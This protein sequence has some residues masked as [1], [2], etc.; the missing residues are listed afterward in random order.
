MRDLVP[1]KWKGNHHSYTGLWFIGFGLFNWYMG[2]DNGELS[3]LIPLWQGLTCVGAFMVVDDVIEHTITA[4][5][6]LRLFYEK[7]IMPILKRI[8]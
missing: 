4:D 6:P 2:V 7:V 1:F 3:T 5:T 8:K